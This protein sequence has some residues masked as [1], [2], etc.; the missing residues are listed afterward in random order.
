MARITGAVLRD[1]TI[2][3]LGGQGDNWYPTWGA[4]GSLYVAM[5]DGAGFAGMRRRYY[6]SRLIR[7]EGT[8]DGEVTFHDVPGYPDLSAPLG[9]NP[10]NPGMQGTRYYGFATISIDG[11]MYQ[12][13]DTWNVPTTAEVLAS[14]GDLRFIG[15][16]LIYSP[17][18]GTTW[19][20]Q[21]GS[22]PVHWEDWD[23]RSAQTMMFWNEPGESFG[24][25]GILQMGQ[26]YSLNTDGYAYI[27]APNGND[28]GTMNQLVMCRVPKDKLLDRSAYEFYTGLNADGGASWSQNVA[29]R[30][31][32]MT[33]PSGWVNRRVHPYAWQA[34]VTYNPGLG[35]Y[36]MGN[37]ATGLADDGTWFGK[38]SYLGVYQSQ[39]PWGPW[40]QFHEDTSWTPGGDERARC[41][42]PIIT[43]NWISDD[44]KSFWMIWTDFQ[45]AEGQEN[46]AEIRER[47]RLATDMT[48]DEKAD[49]LQAMRPYY[50]FNVQ[51][52]ELLTD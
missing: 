22:T 30:G 29:D 38:P 17:D 27:Y 36:I 31:V 48:D 2:Q 51:K 47:I 50:S 21:D 20:N 15:A 1:D 46:Q 37:W 16:K 7:V 35:V 49:A 25:R 12:Y 34:N 5:C 9:S 6:N 32:V 13:L 23:E 10:A 14:D 40:E 26:D 24:V 39:T 4:D 41:Y 11:T 43:P 42:Q 18:G 3:R 33:F 8:P 52:V 28:E 45:S 19:H 44:G